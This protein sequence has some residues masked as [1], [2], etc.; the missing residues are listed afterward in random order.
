MKERR[1]REQREC[2]RADVGHVALGAR[3]RKKV[4]ARRGKPHHEPDERDAEVVAGTEEARLCSPRVLFHL[5]RI[6]GIDAECERRK[7]VGDEVDP[8]NLEW[9]R[10]KRTFDE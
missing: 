7:A 6:G 5:T 9:R 10:G 2:H 1:E 8:E 4:E 3:W